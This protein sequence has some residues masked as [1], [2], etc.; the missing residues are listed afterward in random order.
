MVDCSEICRCFEGFYDV[1]KW[2]A[3]KINFVIVFCIKVMFKGKDY[4]YM[5][6]I[7]FNIM[8]LVVVLGLNLWVNIVEYMYVLCF[9]LFCNLKVEVWI[10][11]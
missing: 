5:V 1:Y 3:Y 9:S 6:Y 2:V 8:Y 7:G 11:N 4:K 10:V